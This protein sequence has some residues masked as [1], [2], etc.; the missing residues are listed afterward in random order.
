MRHCWILATTLG[1]LGMGGTIV[2]PASRAEVSQPNINLEIGRSADVEVFVVGAQPTQKLR[3][4]PKVGTQQILTMQW[5]WQTGLSMG[6]KKVLSMQL[7]PIAATIAAKVT[8]IDDNGDIHYQT[9]YR[10][11]EVKPSASNSSASEK[12][13]AALQKQLQSLVGMQGTYIVTAQG[14]PKSAT[15]TPPKQ[16]S[17]SQQAILQQFSQSLANLSAPFPEQGMGVGGKWRQKVPVK[18]NGATIAQE[19]NYELIKLQ[20]GQATIGFTISQTAQ[21]QKIVAPM[22]GVGDLNLES[23]QSDGKGELIMQL[24]QLLP[25]RSSLNLNSKMVMK[26]GVN[27]MEGRKL[28]TQNQIQLEMTSR[29]D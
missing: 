28:T 25:V 24:D 4:T 6:E 2:P 20:D 8:K 27:G 23:L 13:A 1:F 19:T 21:N 16:I 3:L 22:K 17:A 15:L 5:N 26:T 18:L 29:N 14:K 10:S 7:P 12:A 11:M 9:D